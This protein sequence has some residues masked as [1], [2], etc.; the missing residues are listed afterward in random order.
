[1]ELRR[2]EAKGTAAENTFPV[3]MNRCDEVRCAESLRSAARTPA[4]RLA[5][6][7]AHGHQSESEQYKTDREHDGIHRRAQ[8]MNDECNTPRIDGEANPTLP[9]GRQ[10]PAPAVA[11][12]GKPV[13]VRGI[14]FR[15]L[16]EFVAFESKCT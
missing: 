8:E 12:G 11:L 1:M 15:S 10:P 16:G 9:S 4:R 14:H 3:W 5:L 2:A 13:L 7:P 6:Q